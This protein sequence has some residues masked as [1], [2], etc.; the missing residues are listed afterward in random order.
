MTIE[1]AFFILILCFQ[2]VIELIKLLLG[3]Q[4]LWA[5]GEGDLLVGRGFIGSEFFCVLSCPRGWVANNNP[6]L[7]NVGFWFMVCKA[8]KTDALFALPACGLFFHFLHK[9]ALKVKFQQLEVFFLADGNAVG[10]FVPYFHYVDFSHFVSVIVG[11]YV[12]GYVTWCV[13]RRY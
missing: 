2:F 1:I 10:L 12:V 13:F 9:G 3:P 8:G 7:L 4:Y 11:F 6:V 5:V